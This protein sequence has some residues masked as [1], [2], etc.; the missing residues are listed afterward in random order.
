VRKAL[1]IAVH[2][3]PYSGASNFKQRGDPALGPTNARAARPL[4]IVLQQAFAEAGRRPDLI[5]SAHAHLY[6]RLMYR[7]ADGWE[8]PLLVAG[9]GGHVPVEN[10]FEEC[11]GTS[12]PSKDVPFDAVMPAESTLPAGDSAQV[13]S[14][15]DNS[16]G[17][18]RLTIGLGY[19][20]GEFFAVTSQAASCADV[21]TL[22]MSTHRIHQA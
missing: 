10:L 11:N 8:L 19:I 16:L 22:D 3:P 6:Q 15:N 5:V 17:F 9:C 4:G 21:F 7:Y 14:Y 2:Y 18:L 12:E 13:I 20:R 1:I